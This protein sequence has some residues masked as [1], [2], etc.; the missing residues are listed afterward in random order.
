LVHLPGMKRIFAS[1]EF[2]HHRTRHSASDA[3]GISRATIVNMPLLVGPT[4]TIFRKPRF[5]LLGGIA[6][7]FSTTYLR[8][9]SFGETDATRS[10]GI[11][12]KGSI[13]GALDLGP[14]QA[15]L[16][17]QYLWFEAPKSNRANTIVGNAGGA[18]MTIGYRWFF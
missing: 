12:W 18:G 11:A 13:E 9:T 5:V 4:A 10:F 17:A 15:M 2:G 8:T 1:V 7:G 14:G 16:G 3:H 6:G